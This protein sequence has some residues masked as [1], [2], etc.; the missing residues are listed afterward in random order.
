MRVLV[1]VLASERRVNDEIL[2]S[3][4]LE[5]RDAD[6]DLVRVDTF[7]SG[8]IDQYCRYI[9][10]PPHCR[11]LITPFIQLVCFEHV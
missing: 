10:S 5:S 1:E 8:I 3:F 7:D 11:Y 6:L 4:H 2:W 9:P